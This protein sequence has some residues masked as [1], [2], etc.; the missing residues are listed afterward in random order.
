MVYVNSS[1]AVYII[2]TPDLR[3]YTFLVSTILC[4]RPLADIA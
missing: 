4:L 2:L 3:Q 1:L